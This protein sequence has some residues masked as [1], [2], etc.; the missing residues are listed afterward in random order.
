VQPDDYFFLCS[1]GVLERLSDDALADIIALPR[2]AESKMQD[3]QGLCA[4]CTSD[5]FSAYLG[6]CR[7]GV[8]SGVLTIENFSARVSLNKVAIS[9]NEQDFLSSRYV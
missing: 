1:D 3:I 7:E 9:K 4:G 2:D 6:T 5:N 8:R